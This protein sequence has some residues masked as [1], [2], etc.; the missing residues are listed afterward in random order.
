MKKTSQIIQNLKN[1]DSS[2]SD[3]LKIETSSNFYI[4]DISGQSFINTHCSDTNKCFSIKNK[5][6]EEIFFVTIDG[7]DGLLGFGDS[8]CDAAIF[9]EKDFCFLEFKLNAT[10][11][12]DRA[13]RK[14][15]KKAISQLSNTINLFD[16]KLKRNYSGLNIEAYVSTPQTYPRKDTSWVNFEVQFLEEFGIPLFE[17]NKKAFK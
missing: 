5:N 16:V 8:H 13:I 4:L 11:T 14:N 7:K 15:R 3:F 1:I 6:E 9:N 10:S 2:I 17:S 12:T